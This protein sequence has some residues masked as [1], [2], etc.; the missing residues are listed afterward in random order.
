MYICA[1]DGR[2]LVTRRSPPSVHLSW[3]FFSSTHPH[4]QNQ[5]FIRF[6]LYTMRTGLTC[7]KIFQSDAISGR[8]VIVTYVKYGKH[9]IFYFIADCCSMLQRITVCCRVLQCVAVCCSVLQC[10]AVCYSVLQCVAV[11]CSVLQCVAVCAA[12]CC[13]VLQY[14]MWPYVEYGKHGTSR[15][16]SRYM[17]IHVFT[18]FNIVIILHQVIYVSTIYVC[19]CLQQRGSQSIAFCL[20][21]IFFIFF[22]CCMF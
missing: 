17:P 19:N 16:A 7:G 12:V 2:V 15:F 10:V 20:F 9:G 5:L 6:A 1:D 18:L 21:V 4:T 11:C 14:L 8:D 3:Y 13:I 22:G